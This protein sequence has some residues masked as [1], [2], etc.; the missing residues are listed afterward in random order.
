MILTAITTTACTHTQENLKQ[1]NANL[2]IYYLKNRVFKYLGLSFS[3]L[4]KN[5]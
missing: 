2:I 1:T 4:N 5:E 3:S